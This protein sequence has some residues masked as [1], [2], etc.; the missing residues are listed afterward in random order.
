[1][2]FEI[3][4]TA[5]VFRRHFFW[6][7]EATLQCN[8][9]TDITYTTCWRHDNTF[10]AKISS[11]WLSSRIL[12]FCINDWIPT[13]KKFLFSAKP[14][15]SSMN[16]KK[17]WKKAV[18]TN[19]RIETKQNENISYSSSSIN[20][21]SVSDGVDDLFHP[22]G[23]NAG[24]L[25]YWS[26]RLADDFFIWY[27]KNAICNW[28]RLSAINLS[29]SDRISSGVSRYLLS[30]FHSKLKY[31]SNSPVLHI[32]FSTFLVF[33]ME[34]MFPILFADSITMAWQRWQSWSSG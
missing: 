15:L 17:K 1:M 12:L 34:M 11:V 22:L 16:R 27:F 3:S 4:L 23:Q 32:E 10:W 24:V 26:S 14:P 25:Q 21:S 13:S 28:L 20:S 9:Y 7:L 29:Q 8:S 19:K 18:A 2:L 5:R 31:P 6:I 30:L 33:S